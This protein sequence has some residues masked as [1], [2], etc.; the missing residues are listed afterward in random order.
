VVIEGC[1]F[2]NLDINHTFKDTTSI[3][4]NLHRGG[5]D[6]STFGPMLVFDK[7]TLENVGKGKRNKSDASISLHGVQVAYIQNTRFSDCEPLKLHLVVGE[8]IVKISDCEFNN[9]GKIEDNGEPYTVEN[10]VFNK[11]RIA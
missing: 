1:D 8:P 7:S 10:L 3:V 9:T 2:K 11:I 6:E 4:L 5:G